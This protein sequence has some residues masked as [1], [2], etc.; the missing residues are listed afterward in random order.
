MKRMFGNCR[1][2]IYEL[3][4]CVFSDCPSICPIV[5]NKENRCVEFAGVS[6]S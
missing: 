6:G 3:F 2:N 1:C 5:C 4:Y